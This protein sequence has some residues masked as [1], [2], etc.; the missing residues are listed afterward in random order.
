MLTTFRNGFARPL[1]GQAIRLRQ[2]GPKRGPDGRNSMGER[3]PACKLP[4]TG[5]MAMILWRRS[6]LSLGRGQA[7][8]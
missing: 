2:R 4:A 1:E 8:R 6:G 5:E 3:P 7:G